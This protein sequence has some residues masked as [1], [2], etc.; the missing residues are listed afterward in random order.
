MPA[1]LIRYWDVIPRHPKLKWTKRNLDVIKKIV[2]HQ[3][4]SPSYAGTKDIDNNIKYFVRPGNH[5]AENGCPYIPYHVIIDEDG[6]IYW[7]NPFEDISWHCKGHNTDSVGIALMGSFDG[8]GFKGKDGN[9]TKAQINSLV[10]VLNGFIMYMF[11][12]IKKTDVYGHCEL[13]P[14]RKPS[15]PGDGAMRVLKEWRNTNG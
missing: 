7:T 5:I 11:N 13:D 8:P 9:P 1:E 10:N 4:A 14:A 15:C 6:V 2:V 3:L 12:N